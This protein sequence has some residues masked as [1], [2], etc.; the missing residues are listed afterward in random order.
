MKDS[1]KPDAPSQRGFRILAVDHLGL[2]LRP[3][4]ATFFGS[5]LG[6]PFLGEE[7]VVEQ[8]TNTQMFGASHGYS[9]GADQV[10]REP[11]QPRLELL[12]ATDASSAVASFMA[13]KGPG[14]HHIAL[15][16]DHMEGA[17]AHLKRCQVEIVQGASG[18]EIMQGAGGCLIAFIH[19]RST[20]GI[21]VELT[22][23]P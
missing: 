20:G 8:K 13:K 16:V 12:E 17:L 6:L 9:G 2:A 4:A 10:V 3:E 7:E 18:Q 19:P 21:L 23:V 11:L 5:V 22:Q 1:T 15:R 14:V